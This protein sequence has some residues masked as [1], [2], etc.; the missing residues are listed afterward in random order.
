MEWEEEEFFDNA[1]SYLSSLFHELR[2][3]RVSIDLEVYIFEKSETANDLIQILKEAVARGVLVRF[4]VDG[5][6]SLGF[7][8]EFG[9]AVTGIETKIYHPMPWSGWVVKK[10]KVLGS[11]KIKIFANLF[12]KINSRNHRKV[13]VVDRRT[14]FLA[15]SNISDVHFQKTQ[16]QKAWHDFGVRVK[17]QCVELLTF[18]F[19]LAWS[20]TLIENYNI[21]KLR[22][23]KK[24]RRFHRYF[25]L[26]YN[27]AVRLRAGRRALKRFRNAQKR[28]WVVTPYFI[29]TR[30]ILR[31]LVE[32]ASEGVDVRFLFP[33]H[34]DV[35]I[36]KWVMKTYYN[37]MIEN[38]MQIFEYSPSILHAKAMIVDDW[39]VL[40]SMNLNSR[41]LFHDLEANYILQSQ[42]QMTK[43]TRAIE[44]D[45][46]V[47]ER[48]HV[49]SFTSWYERWLGQ[50]LLILKYWL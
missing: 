5:V 29:P 27:I 25:L 6:G 14:A 19:E 49:A 35:P 38:G 18:G 24:L 43:L 21:N 33:K 47:S 30:K 1:D 31:L 44:N 36:E 13:C 28:I 23:S 7:L 11:N 45:F 9:S 40:G 41:S 15:S 22:A 20:N 50:I 2:H 42:E 3:A 32:K 26:N 16:G 4:L 17:G 12:S 48:V 10:S 46:Q 34:S 39:F 37:F 8:E